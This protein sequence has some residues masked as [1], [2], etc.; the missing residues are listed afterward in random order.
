MRR[1]GLGGS[2]GLPGAARR[3]AL[4]RDERSRAANACTASAELIVNLHGGTQPLPELR[5]DRPA[6]LPGDRPGPAADRAAG[7]GCRRRSTS[8]S[9]TVA[10]FTFAENCGQPDC[11]LP[12]QRALPIP[13]RP[14]SRWSSISGPTARR[15]RPTSSRRSATGARTWRDV[16]FEGERYTWSKHHE[17]LKL[18]DLPAAH[19]QA[20]EL[21][22]S[23]CDAAGARAAREQRLAGPRRRSSSRRDIDRYRDYIGASRGEFTVAKDQ[24]VRLRTGWFSDR[25]ATYLACGR[26]VVTQ[27]TGFGDVL[28]TGEGLFAFDSPTRRRGGGGDRCRLLAPRG[29]G[30][31]DRA[32]ALQ[33][34]GG[35]RL[36]AR[37]ARPG[38]AR[39]VPPAAIG[40]RVPAGDGARAGLAAAD[41]AAARDGRGRAGQR[42]PASTRTR[43]TLGRRAPA[44]SSSPTTASPSPGS[45]WRRCSPTAPTHDFELIVVDNG[46]SDGTRA[47]LAE[48][49]ERDARVRVLLNG[50]NMGFAP[51]CNQGLGLALGEHLVLLNNDTMVAPG[52]LSGLLPHLRKPGVGL[53]GP[54]TN[55]I[56]NEAEV[57][58]R[59]PHLGRVPRVRPPSAPASTRATG[60]R[61]R[62]P[63]M[64]CLA[65]RRQTYSAPRGRSTSA[66]RSACSRTTTTP[67]ARGEAGYQL[68]CAEERRRP[69]LRRGI[70][71]Q[72]RRRR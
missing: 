35:A 45:A 28:P 55:R 58:D 36:D 53:V 42:R 4:L 62:T 7:T 67:S 56:G 49:A 71:R 9:R 34:R 66:T 26:P 19:G 24:N 15:S 61:S 65:M 31:R 30:P 52:W 18:L 33:S 43:R 22:L 57:D 17:F 44:S 20:F 72:A 1:F 46:S 12:R 39:D 68:R 2:L 64:F 70:V 21:A 6:R 5:R 32:R 3:R 48:L 29:G 47:Y 50:R 23:S 27:D 16:T 69:P 41:H 13:C 10:F 51:A 37:R 54:V 63:A 11:G 60:S 59:L 38:P 40:V 8:S 14:A 25:S